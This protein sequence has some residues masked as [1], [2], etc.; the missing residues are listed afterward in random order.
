[1]SQR[2]W[3]LND[4][5]ELLKYAYE[6]DN[7]VEKLINPNSDLCYI[8]FSGNGL[9]YPDE[10]EVFENVVLKADRYEWTEISKSDYVQNI[11]GKC[12]F[13]RDIYKSWYVTGINNRIDTINKLVD[14]LKSKVSGYR[15][16]TV[17]NSAGGYMAAL[18]GAL[19]NAEIIF[20]FSGQFSLYAEEVVDS[21]YFLN[22][23]KNDI[24]RSSYYN[25]LPYIK[26]Y[27]P[28]MY[29]FPNY[30][31]YD[32]KQ[33]ELVKTLDNV[34]SF[35]F[36]EYKHGSTMKGSDIP[37]VLSLSRNR[38]ENLYYMYKNKVINAEEWE[39]EIKKMVE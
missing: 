26:D 29:F 12:I 33:S 13:I 35:A 36:D 39:S 37:I 22:K 4:S 8:F 25:I 32:M 30:S 5:N 24:C 34:Y 3:K 9:Y 28:I 20:D 21:Y 7:Y 38:L 19:I 14:V 23:Y 31:K 11:A 18:V 17:G 16:R 27:V 10:E 6:N 2:T 1:M 15:V